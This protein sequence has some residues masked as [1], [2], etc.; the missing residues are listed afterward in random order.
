M[1][2][3]TLR[4]SAEQR[5]ENHYL[6]QGYPDRWDPQR[7][8]Q[9]LANPSYQRYCRRILKCFYRG[10]VAYRRETRL[11]QMADLHECYGSADPQVQRIRDKL[12]HD[13]LHRPD[14]SRCALIMQFIDTM[15]ISEIVYH[16][17]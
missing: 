1:I 11:E 4:R 9:N 2:V 16:G 17:L 6:L 10:H 5:N 14:T 12:M 3:R 15:D 8:E 13:A 7:N